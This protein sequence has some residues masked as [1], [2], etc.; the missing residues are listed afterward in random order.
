[1]GSAFQNLNLKKNP[2]KIDLFQAEFLI[3]CKIHLKFI[4]H[5]IMT[6]SVFSDRVM[7]LNQSNEIRK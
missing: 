7:K 3:K 2:P 5:N 4:Y 1:M 6:F